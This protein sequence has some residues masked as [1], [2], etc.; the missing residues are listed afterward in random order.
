MSAP[1]V[2]PIP[3]PVN[4][5]A[6]LAEAHA[7]FRKWLGPDYDLDALDIVLAT[8][9][10]ERLDGDPLWTLVLSGSGNAKTETV[11]A[12]A[13]AG[14]IITS[15]I[16]SQGALISATAKKERASDA[17]GGLLRKLEPRGLLVVKDFTSIIG[18]NRDMRSEVLGAFREIYDGRWS[19]NV[20]SDGGQ[21]L[22]WA[23]RISLVGAVTSVWD[24]AH[25]VIAA[26]GDRF[27][28]VRM[29]STRGRQESGRQAISNTGKESEMRSELAAAV[30]AVIGAMDPEPID[31]MP[32]EVDCLMAAA[33]IVTLARTAVDFD[34][35]GDVVDADA[36]EMPTRFAK[37]LAQVVRG[38]VAVGI[39]R[40]AA[41]ELALRAARDSIPP[42][43]LAILDD[44]ALHRD[45]TT[46]EI[47]RRVGKPRRTVDRQLQALHMLGLVSCREEE[48]QVAGRPSSIWHYSVVPQ[49]DTRALRGAPVPELLVPAW[50]EAGHGEGDAEGVG[51]EML[52]PEFG[53]VEEV[54]GPE[55]SPSASDR[56][57]H[58]GAGGEVVGPEMSVGSGFRIEGLG[59]E[60]AY[61]P[62]DIS[63]TAYTRESPAMLLSGDGIAFPESKRRSEFHETF[64]T[65]TDVETK[66]KPYPHMNTAS[67][68]FEELVELDWSGYE[69]VPD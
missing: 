42:L 56:I 37:Q 48:V 69:N 65:N 36:P 51:P 60:V 46:T 52:V 32:R 19:R 33:D 31:L 58:A 54:V 15:T 7:V 3:E 1:F 24:R 64:E 45:A 12:L 66:S 17:T 2:P 21:T 35:R 18:M 8:A 43:R 38:A 13:G 27:V 49:I 23:G 14:A 26:M 16:S 9:A 25:G 61:P 30:G 28:I 59:D 29:D 57:E 47:R 50:G 4:R 11:S 44:L 22:E 67:L 40:R 63:G 5:S 68:S 62:T 10:V 34:Y 55:M 41:V 6:I 53:G 39:D 20:G